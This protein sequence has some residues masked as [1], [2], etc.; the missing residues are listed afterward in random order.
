MF[1]WHGTVSRSYETQGGQADLYLIDTQ[2]RIV[3]RLVG[4]V[5]PE[6]LQRFIVHID[7]HV[8]FSGK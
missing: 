5:S 1:A 2:G 8:G 4:V 7:L 3:L 6:R